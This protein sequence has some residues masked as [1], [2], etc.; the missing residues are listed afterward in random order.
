MNPIQD[1]IK[2]IMDSIE[3]FF[4]DTL[5]GASENLLDTVYK[6]FEMATLSVREQVSQTP[7]SFSMSMLRT[8]KSISDSAILPIAGVMITYIFCYDLYQMVAEKNKGNEISFEQM[9]WLI[10]KTGLGIK[11]TANSFTITLAIIDLG[12][13]ITDKVPTSALTMPKNIS[14][15]LLQNSKT[16]GDAI[17]LMFVSFI[18]LVVVAVMV[19][20]IF[21]VAWS[22]IITIF[23]YVGV[24][25]IAFATFFNKD[26]VGSI[27]QSYI[28]NI[29]ALT[30]QGFFMMLCLVIYS[31]MLSK[32]TKMMTTGGNYFFSLIML[33]VS[34][35]VL[36]LSLTKSHSYAKSVVGAF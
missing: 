6:T 9:M 17:A 28:K 30:L 7:Q 20:L 35:G 4:V 18:A 2:G 29:I 26:W 11:L 23:L 33:L 8:V 24:A 15:M 1:I 16:T 3:K 13:W 5:N 19:A 14:Q 21:L 36:V 27:A 31:G 25:P 34:M 12:K 22:R 10:L 32:I